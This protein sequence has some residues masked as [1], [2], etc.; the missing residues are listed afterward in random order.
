MEAAKTGLQYPAGL[1]FSPRANAF[2]VVE[3]PGAGQ[4]PP[5]ATDAVKLTPFANRIGSA[6]I[7]AQIRDPINMTYDSKFQR[8]LVLQ[9]PADQLLEI[10]EGPDGNLDPTTLNRYAVSR[11]GLQ[12]PQG[13]TVDSASGCL[14]ILDAVGPRIVRVQ[15]GLDGSFDGAVI[16]ATN[17]QPSGLVAVRGLALDPTTSHLY[18]VDSVEQKLYELTQAGQVVTN[19]DLSQFR[20]DDPEAMVF[21]PSG[22]QTD[23]PLQLSLYLADSGD[24]AAQG[25]GQIVEFSLTRP[26]AAAAAAATA[27]SFQSSLVRTT[28]MAGFSPPSPDPDGLTYLPLSN[29]LLASDSEV[30]ETVGGITHFAGANLWEMTLDGNVVRT[31]NISTVAPTVVPMTDEPTGVAWSPAN[32]HFFFSDDDEYKVWNLNPGA[33]GLIGTADDSWT[34]FDTLASGSGDPEGITYDTWNNQLFVVDGTNAEIYQ[35]TVTGSLVAHFDVAQY[36]VVDP[37]SVEFNP[38]SGTL[39][40]LSKS[41]NPVI[42]ETTLGGS[43]LQTIDV[44]ADN[45]L[46][47][48]GLA[49]APASDGSG[50]KHFY[51]VDRGI[52]NNEDPRVIDG[53]MYEMTGAPGGT[54]GPTYTPSATATPTNTRTPR[55]SRTPTPTRTSTPTRTPT[56]AA[57][58]TSTATSTRTSTPT[59]TPTYTATPTATSTRTSTPTYTAT[60]S[61][62]ATSTPTMTPTEV[63]TDTPTST[64]TL[65]S[66]SET[67]TSTVTNTP[68]NTGMSTTTTTAMPTATNTSTSTPTRTSTPTPTDTPPYTRTPT[69]TTTFTPTSTPT[70]TGTSTASPT[71]T[72]TRTST[73]TATNTSTATP[74]RTPTPTATNTRTATSTRTSTPTNTPTYTST[75]TNTPTNTS[76]STPTSTATSTPTNTATGTGTNTPTSTPKNTAT[77]TPTNTPTSTSMS[78]ATAPATPTNTTTATPTSAGTS[79]PT[80]TNT[81]TATATFTATS[82][83]TPTDTATAISTATSTP[84][85]T[86]TATAISTAT[87]TPTPTYT[88]ASTT[89]SVDVTIAGNLMGTY[90]L[91]PSEAQRH[92]YAGVD[93]GP[94][95]VASTNGM[96]IIAAERDSWWDG[97]TWSDYAQLMGLPASQVSDT[98]VFPAYNNVT[99]D[100]QLRFGNVDTVDTTVTVTI[101]GVFKGSYLL[102]P[103]QAVRANYAGLD[104]GPVVVQGSP[105]V[106]IIAAERDSWWDGTTW[107][108]Y[109]QLMGLPASLLSDSYVFPAYNNVT[110][111]EQ[112][113]FGNVDTV[114]TTVTV[115]IG[116][117][118]RGSY[119]L[120]PSQAVRVNYAGVDSGPVVVQGT[121]GVKIIAAERELL[122]GWH[123]LE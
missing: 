104:S 84:T 102:H 50:E 2:Y 60:P 25:S 89:I 17:L 18:L 21:A 106:K 99:L 33:D 98:Y 37:E 83:P 69:Q 6:R 26:M 12:N 3:G 105:G 10:R 87:S 96:H 101:G 1:A 48:A 54:P 123:D 44:S 38:D 24:V 46:T 7:E 71:A 80:P 110:L 63:A 70:N 85:P 95:V 49:Y 65:E 16:S 23:D 27:S 40:V 42:V 121:P 76:T 66:P 120:H 22:D 108:S 93:S 73:L 19:R 68:T 100:E 77:G 34:S 90:T 5:A 111:D 119:L 78:T 29:T 32:G 20:L 107:S 31:A 116:G 91:R 11:F 88:P 109:A 35:F 9:S 43:L 113:R 58:N 64:P 82:T 79:T 97:T 75:P 55:P 92:S 117:I 67:P 14:F 47:P 118:F 39:F 62:T 36:G 52:D 13:I 81:A 30:E 56:Y 112:L 15:P 115:T 103:S 72:P 51:I 57:T 59:N 4:S 28:N 41:D 114:D 8:L 74:T 94:V 61:D 86:N 53:K 122:V 45:A